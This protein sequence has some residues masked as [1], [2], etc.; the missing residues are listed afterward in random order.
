MSRINRMAGEW[1]RLVVIPARR[2]ALAGVE[3]FVEADPFDVVEGDGGGARGP[4][5]DGE[6]KVTVAE[7]FVLADEVAHA[8]A[9]VLVRLEAAQ[10]QHFA[11]SLGGSFKDAD[12]F[13]A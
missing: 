5:A 12:P 13:A 6:V 4:V 10:L 11:G 9:T 7:D 3:G 1:L 8:G 2:E